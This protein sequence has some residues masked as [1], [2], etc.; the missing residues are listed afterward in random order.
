METAPKTRAKYRWRPWKVL[1][2]VLAGVFVAAGGVLALGGKEE[3][4]AAPRAAPVSPVEFPGVRSL[5]GSDPVLN[6]S[7]AAPTTAAAPDDSLSPAFLRGGLSFFVAFAVAFAFRIFVKLAMFFVGLWLASLFLLSSAGYIEI[8]WQA[9]DASFTSWAG[10]VG[11]QFE[12][13]RTFIQGSLPSAGLAGL[14]LLAGFR[15]R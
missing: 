3:A 14:G 8:H 11:R 13:F 6:P 2:F 9:I 4:P 1:L 7:A 15:R 10:S 12:S 5:V